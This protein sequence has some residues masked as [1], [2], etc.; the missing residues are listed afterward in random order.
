MMYLHSFTKELQ[1]ARAE[2]RGADDCDL[3]FSVKAMWVHFVI[4]MPVS[5]QWAVNCG[6]LKAKEAKGSLETFGNDFYNS[7][8][9]CW[10]A[11]NI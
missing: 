10:N 7:Y 4:Y 3:R 1:K 5:E 6:M 2:I 9:Q 11:E 8:L